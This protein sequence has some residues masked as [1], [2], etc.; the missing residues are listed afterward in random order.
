[1]VRFADEQRAMVIAEGIERAE[2]LETVKRLGVHLLQ[3]FFLQRPE[4][5][6]A[7]TAGRPVTGEVR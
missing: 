7:V 4:R 6:R 1:M 2:E 3:G 5:A